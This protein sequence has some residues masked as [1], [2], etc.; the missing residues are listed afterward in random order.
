MRARLALGKAFHRVTTQLVS[1]PVT[2]GSQAPAGVQ[3]RI[4]SS[5]AP[6]PCLAPV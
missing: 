1:G 2:L 5:I 3:S 6:R 4:R